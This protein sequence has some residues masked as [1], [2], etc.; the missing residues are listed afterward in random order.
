[1]KLYGVSVRSSY[2]AGRSNNSSGISDPTLWWM[3]SDTTKKYS[4]I[5]W[6]KYVPGVGDM[7]GSELVFTRSGGFCRLVRWRWRGLASFVSVQMVAHATAAL[8]TL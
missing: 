4:S 8:S 1:M 5:M 6:Q 2:L 3:L 7:Y